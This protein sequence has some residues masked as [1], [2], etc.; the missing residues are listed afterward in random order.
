MNKKYIGLDLNRN[1]GFAVINDDGVP[2]YTGHRRFDG[3]EGRA[4]RDFERFLKQDLKIKDA[5]FVAYEDP[6]IRG[7]ASF[8]KLYFGFRA[9]LVQAC[10]EAGVP[11]IPIAVAT[12]KKS[13]VGSGKATKQQ[14]IDK[15][16]EV[17][18]LQVETDHEADAIAVAYAVRKGVDQHHG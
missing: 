18:D 14:V 6:F 5:L 10:Y 2:T 13:F 15:V 3:M 7:R 8:M 9:V 17:Y 11:A 12:W 1:T 16:K 4:Y